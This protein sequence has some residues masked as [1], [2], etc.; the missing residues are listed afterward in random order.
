MFLGYFFNRELEEEKVGE[1]LTLKQDSLSVHEYGLKFT[2]L[3]RY[4]PNMV[5]NMRSGMSM[6]VV[7]FSRLS[8]KEG[9]ITILIRNMDI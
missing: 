3:S 1:F 2:Q 6:F 5:K 8:S 7:R 9:R 4:T